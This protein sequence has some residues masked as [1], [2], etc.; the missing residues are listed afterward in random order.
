MTIKAQRVFKHENQ[1][2]AISTVKQVKVVKP[3]T[4][5]AAEKVLTPLPR[6]ITWLESIEKIHSKQQNARQSFN[7]L[8]ATA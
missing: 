3:T 4:Q 7:Q 1:P 5:V 8:F 6:R 2:Q